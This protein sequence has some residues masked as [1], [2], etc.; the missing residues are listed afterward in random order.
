MKIRLDLSG[1]GL[2]KFANFVRNKKFY[3]RISYCKIVY[4]F[5]RA[6]IDGSETFSMQILPLDLPHLLPVLNNREVRDPDCH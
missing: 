1:F 2:H 4:V 5:S 3:I 6:A